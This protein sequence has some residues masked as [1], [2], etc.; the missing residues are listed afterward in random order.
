MMRSFLVQRTTNQRKSRVF[1]GRAMGFKAAYW[2]GLRSQS[3]TGFGG[4]AMGFD[5]E[6]WVSR[7]GMGRGFCVT[8]TS[9]L[10]LSN[11]GSHYSADSQHL[12]TACYTT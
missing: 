3:R 1:G 7:P 10:V 11:I 9:D 12:S 8:L 5:A 2:R 6:H 4:R